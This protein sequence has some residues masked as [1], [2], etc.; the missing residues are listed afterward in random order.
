MQAALASPAKY[1]NAESWVLGDSTALPDAATLAHDINDRYREDYKNAWQDFLLKTNVPTFQD[2]AQSVA[3]LKQLA[4]PESPLLSLFCVAAQ[5]TAVD[6]KSISEPFQA[7]Q[8]VVP[9]GC[10]D[11]Y[12]GPPN[13]PYVDA[14]AKVAIALD[15]EVA[16]KPQIPDALKQATNGAVDDVQGAVL[17]IAG[18]FPS[19][20]PLGV[21]RRAQTLLMEP[22]HKEQFVPGVSAGAKSLCD[23]LN[24]VFAKAPF[25]PNG[26]QAA[27]I[28]DLQYVFQPESGLLAK[29]YNDEL[30]Q[31]GSLSAEDGQFHP[32]AGAKLNPHFLS[33]FNRAEQIQH[34]LYA[35]GSQP[36][37]SFKVTLHAPDGVATWLVIDGQTLNSTAGAT[38]T[39][40]FVWPG[41]TADGV[42]L[43]AG[44]STFQMQSW[45]GA[46][47]VFEF[48]SKATQI[49][50]SGD[51]VQLAFTPM[52]GGETHSTFRFDVDFSGGVPVFKRNYMSSLT[53][54]CVTRVQ[55]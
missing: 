19:K 46:L 48:F 20:D 1:L 29:L 37:V 47:G 2:D 11:K 54:Q 4:G 22:V 51:K 10:S 27:G 5:N 36:K 31:S 23:T 9:P 24:Q 6:D 44:T 55:Q 28:D 33:F 14:L 39:A 52:M 50:F 53:G 3:H 41:P 40:D 30:K 32:S 26:R 12:I 17:Q 16:Q 13:K 25:N 45:P 7:L 21:G 42:I 49:Q 8:S 18:G 43:K 35:G 34:A 15:N 38:A